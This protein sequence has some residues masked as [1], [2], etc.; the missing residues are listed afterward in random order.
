MFELGA[1]YQIL[2]EV[3]PNCEE[4]IDSILYFLGKE[5]MVV[6]VH[7]VVLG[8]MTDDEIYRTYGSAGYALIE[9]YKSYRGH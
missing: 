8:E 2:K 6:Y 9:F 3:Y 7:D 4:L 1:C 5:E